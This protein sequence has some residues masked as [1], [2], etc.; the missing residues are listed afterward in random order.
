MTSRTFKRIGLAVLV[1]GMMTA[2]RAAVLTVGAAGTACASPQYNTVASAIAAASA[3]ETITICPAIYPEQ[4]FTTKPLTLMGT[5]MAP[6]TS[7][8]GKYEINRALIQPAMTS[9]FH[10]RAIRHRRLN[11][12]AVHLAY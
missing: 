9:V 6:A 7:Q 1:A 5:V 2:S 10:S 3:G 12:S 11:H 4:L 8:Q